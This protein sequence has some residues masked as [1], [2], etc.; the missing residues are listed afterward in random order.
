MHLL[1]IQVCGLNAQSNPWLYY[2]Y[3]A[4]LPIYILEIGV[5]ALAFGTLALSL[6]LNRQEKHSGEL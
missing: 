6:K 1:I 5:M 4:A 3:A 2:V